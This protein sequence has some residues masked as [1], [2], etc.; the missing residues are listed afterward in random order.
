MLRA[1]N[2]KGD[3]IGIFSPYHE[4][5]VDA[6][7]KMGGRF[8]RSE[9]CWVFPGR[10]REQVANILQSVYGADPWEPKC[11]VRLKA[12]EELRANKGPVV[13]G[14]MVLANARSRDSGARVGEGVHLLSGEIRSGG[15]AAHWL[16]LVTED[17]EFEIDEFPVRLLDEAGEYHTEALEVRAVHDVDA[18][19]ELRAERARL[20]ARIAEIDALLEAD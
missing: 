6:A 20:V 10:H 2:Y 17:S 18:M 19:D 8:H 16:S 14:G 13:E 1:K 12:K 11:R 15:S 4:D 9:G 7:H 3:Q 5:F